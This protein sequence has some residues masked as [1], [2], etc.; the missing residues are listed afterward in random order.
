MICIS[1]NQESRR[2]ALVD[3]FNSAKQCDLLEIRLDRFSISPDLSELVARKPAPIIMSCRRQ[4]DGGYWDGSEAQRLALLRQCILSEPDYVEIELDVAD[5]IPPKPPTKRVISYHVQP[6]DTATDIAN[7]YSAAQSK[8]PDVIKLVSSAQ[9]PEEAWP[10]VQI[11]A[12]P[13]VPTVAMGIGKSGIMLTILGK[14][15]GAPWTYAALERGMETYPG[16][17]TVSDLRNVYHYDKIN[18][19]TRLIGVTGF[20]ERSYHSVA[21]LNAALAH[22]DLPARCWPMGVGSLKLFQ[23][24]V[25]A[26]KVT[27]IVVDHENQNVLL[28]LANDNHAT[29]KY[30]Q[31]TDLILQKGDNWHG[32]FT[33]AQAAVAALEK[34]LQA[35]SKSDEPMRGKMILIAGAN[36]VAKTMAAD[37]QHKGANITLASQQ[38]EAAQDL[39]KML[40]CRFVMQEA[41]YSTLHDVL[42][43][44]EDTAPDEKTKKGGLHSSIFKPGQTVLDLTAEFRKTPLLREAQD[45]GSEIVDPRQVLLCQLELQGKMLTG[46]QVPSQVLVSA[47]PEVEEYVR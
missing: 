13:A 45:R 42:I 2:F 23:K 21:G 30:A 39:A 24:V 27:G 37:L 43:V 31:A 44:C 26:V 32:Y 14:K 25:E 47:I 22:L 12:K 4:Q 10:V 29:A 38:K 41:M 18:R 6:G 1:I 7:K 16:Q 34:S 19:S 17:P 20:E 8:K 46:K 35:K 11:L 36:G 28:G 5:E 33:L 15:I 3:M 9:T 40:D